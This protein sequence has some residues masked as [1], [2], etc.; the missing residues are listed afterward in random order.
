MFNKHSCIVS[1]AKTKISR[2]QAS[3]WIGHVLC[4]DVNSITKV[5]IHWTP[6]GKR[7]RGRPKTT[8]RR[9][10]ETEMKNVNHS[11]GTIQRLA[12][13]S[14]GSRGFVAAL[15]ASWR[16]EEHRS[17]SSPVC[18]WPASEWCPSCGSRSSFSPPQFFVRLS[19]VNASSPLPETSVLVIIIK[20]ARDIKL[21]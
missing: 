3:F 2:S 13:D 6:E 20:V 18:H 1:T 19:S 12:R 9:T 11:W 8:W 16:I 5:A 10:V 14:Q 4:K 21:I 7:K 15:Y 17:S